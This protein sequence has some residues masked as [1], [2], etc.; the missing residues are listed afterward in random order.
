M[1]TCQVTVTEDNS[2]STTLA[3]WVA[4]LRTFAALGIGM[5]I[6]ATIA[7]LVTLKTVEHR[8]VAS[9]SL[10]KKLRFASKTLGFPEGF[11][12]FEVFRHVD[13]SGVVTSTS[14]CQKC[15]YPGL[16]I[17]IMYPDEPKDSWYAY[18]KMNKVFRQVSAL[19]ED[20]D[21]LASAR[22]QEEEN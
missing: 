20:G 8:T 14:Y 19:P 5:I 7:S 2:R 3:I 12:G 9:L 18:D 15:G 17:S 22:K 4:R 16:G 10:E 21:V 1:K 11:A 6:V 13:G